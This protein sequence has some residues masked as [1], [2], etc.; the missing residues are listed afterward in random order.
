MEKIVVILFTIQLLLLD[1]NL[2]F[3]ILNN[4]HYVKVANPVPAFPPKFVNPFKNLLFL[5][6]MI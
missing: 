5:Y 1:F 2:S 4:N 3:W 6:R